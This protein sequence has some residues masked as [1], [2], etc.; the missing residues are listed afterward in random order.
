MELN[1]WIA[2]FLA[3]VTIAVSPGNGAVLSMNHGLSYGVR[4]T[5]MSIL[6]LQAGLLVILLL[7]AF[8]LGALLLASE[9]LFT[10]VKWAG[11]AY[12]VWL[13]LALW[14]APVVQTEHGIAIAASMSAGKRFGLGFFTNVTNPKGIVFLVAVLPQFMNPNTPNLLLEVG[15]L[16]A[17][18]VGVD[19]IVMH[20]YAALAAQL[21]G[22]FKDA[23][24]MKLQNR[25]FGAVLM[26]A[27]AAVLTVRRA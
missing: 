15:I 24:A 9:A 21:S 6:G 7:S 26:A 4:K 27:G 20:G 19:L 16:A 10:A 23:K 13:G 25:V 3:C 22:F 14:R 1:A 5:S 17:T 8:G 18:M 2:Y 12:L 11:A